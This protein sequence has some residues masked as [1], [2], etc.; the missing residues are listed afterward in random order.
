MKNLQCP[1]CQQ[2]ATKLSGLFFKHKKHRGVF[3]CENCGHPLIKNRKLH[4]ILIIA[5]IGFTILAMYFQI[6]LLFLPFFITFSWL[7]WAL[8]IPFESL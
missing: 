6:S 4:N 2:N 5:I 1:T 7:I 8:L 3:K